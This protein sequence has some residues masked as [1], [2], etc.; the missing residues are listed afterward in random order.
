L[1]KKE[2]T[3]LDENL[4]LQYLGYITGNGA[5][6]YYNPIPGMNFEDTMKSVILSLQKQDIPVKYIEFDS[7]WY[8]RNYTSDNYTGEG[9][10]LLWEPRPDA[11]PDGVGFLGMVCDF[12]CGVANI[13]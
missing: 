1:G 3:P 13:N 11:F 9:G 4:S 10:F 2:R 8:Y 5:Y 12:L 6:Y 7:W